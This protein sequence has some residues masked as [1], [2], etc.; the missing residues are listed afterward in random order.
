VIKAFVVARPHIELS[1][2]LAEEIIE[3]V[4]SRCGRHQSPGEIQF[5]DSLPK[6]HSGKIQRFLLRQAGA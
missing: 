3:F 2:R 6:T 1:P 4:K 5:V